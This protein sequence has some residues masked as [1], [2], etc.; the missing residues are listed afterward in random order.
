MG[1]AERGQLVLILGRTITLDLSKKGSVLQYGTLF[2]CLLFSTWSYAAPRVLPLTL[3][4]E[5][6]EEENWLAC[7]TECR[8]IL[9]TC[10]ENFD[11]MLLKAKSEHQ[12]KINNIKDLTFLSQHPSVSEDIKEKASYEL[13]RI[14][15]QKGQFEKSY[16]LFKHLFLTSSSKQL[17]LKSGC[18]LS[19]L[20]KDAKTLKK[21]DPN[22]V[23]QLQ[24]AE[25]LWSNNLRSNV[26]IVSE[27]N[28]D[29]LS[30]KPGQWLIFFYRNFVRPAIGNRCSLDPSCSEYGLRALK[31]HG[32]FGI[33]F[34]ADRFIREP[35]VVKEKEN[36]IRTGTKMRYSDPLEKHDYW[37]K[38]D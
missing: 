5:L 2:L 26:K 7:R 14:Y 12:L 8:R 23:M 22:L 16:M 38:N 34:I 19:F 18:A 36:P 20:L 3:A 17:F 35:D 25:S 13:G 32:L 31:K 9:E 21:K 10:P 1:R 29:R 33:G 11:A 15:W 37:I 6:Y 4:E 30:G 27:K 28:K 24:T